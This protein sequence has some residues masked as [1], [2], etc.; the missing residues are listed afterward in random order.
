VLWNFGF[1]RI[2]Q[3]LGDSMKTKIPQMGYVPWEAFSCRIAH[4][5][6]IL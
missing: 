4:F 5:W 1:D 6:A 3:I 2:A